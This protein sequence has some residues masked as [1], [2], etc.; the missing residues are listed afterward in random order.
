LEP[1]R[2]GNLQLCSDL[3]K[4]AAK[5]YAIRSAFCSYALA[6][7]NLSIESRSSSSLVACASS[8]NCSTLVALAIGAVML[9]RDIN[10]ANATCAGLAW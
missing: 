3:R 4:S 9:G 1:F 5:S 7:F 10:Q 2:A 8:F 6:L